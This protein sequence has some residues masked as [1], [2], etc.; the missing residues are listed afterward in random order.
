[1]AHLDITDQ[2]VELVAGILDAWRKRVEDTGK[3][4]DGVPISLERANEIYELVRE[5]HGG[6]DT[7]FGL[8]WEIVLQEWGSEGVLEALDQETVEE[9][10]I[11]NHLD[12]A[13]LLRQL[14]DDAVREYYND[15]LKP[16]R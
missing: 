6:I 14:D 2:Q 10:V 9:W 15:N 13:A 4:D 8:C 11:D 3:D 1:M 12:T 16:R 7:D 5:L